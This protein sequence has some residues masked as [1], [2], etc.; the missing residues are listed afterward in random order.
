MFNIVEVQSVKL[1]PNGWLLNGS[2]S[3]PDAPGNSDREA[4]LKWIAAGNVPEPADG[5]TQEQLIQQA[6]MAVYNLL[7]QTAHQYD[8]RNF[9]E[10]AQFINSNIWKAEADSLLAWQDTLWAKVY[11]LLKSHIVNIDDFVAQLPKYVSLSNS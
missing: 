7:D 6:K 8:Y 2:V 11:E 3:V 4:I 1:Q 9:A 5:P 10:V